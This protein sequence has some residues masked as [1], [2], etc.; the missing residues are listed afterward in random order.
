MNKGRS[1]RQVPRAREDWIEIP[2]PA[3]IAE[4]VFEAAGRVSRDNSKWSPRNA[5]DGAWLLRALVR[6]G[7]CN[8]GVSC[9]KMNG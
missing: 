1:T 8:V 3:I 4:D 9:H 7:A 2:V 5:D 6:C